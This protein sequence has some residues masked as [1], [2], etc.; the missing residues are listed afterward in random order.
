MNDALAL[1]DQ[2]RIAESAAHRDGLRGGLAAFDAWFA[3]YGRQCYTQVERVPLDELD[4]W[5]TDPD[6]GDLHHHTGRFFTVHG[7]EVG[8]PGTPVPLWTQPIIDQPEVGILGILARRIEGVLHF[9][10][11]AK[12]EPGNAGGLQLSPTVQATRS[13]YTRAHRGGSVPYLEHFQDIHR[14]PGVLADVRQSEQ[15]AW[16]YRKRNRNVVIET[17][18]EVE[19][20]EGYRWMTLGQIHR[21]LSRDDVVNM[22]AR[23]VLACLPFTGAGGSHRPGKGDGDGFAAALRRSG[24]AQAPAVHHMRDILSWITEMRTTTDVATR[25]L[26]LAALPAWQRTPQRIT[27]ESGAFFDVI[28][29]RVSARGREVRSWCQPMIEPADRGVVAFLTRTVEGVL[30]VLVHARAEAGFA[31]VVELAPTVQCIPSSYRALPPQALPP[32]LP[33][34]LDA[35]AERIR[36]DTVLS[37]EGGRFHRAHNRYL[38]VEASAEVPMDHPE[39]RW[40]TLHQ[41]AGLLRHSHYVNVQARSL[42]ACLHSL[43]G[44]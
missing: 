21:L 33:E 43:Y 12:A 13:N 28:G 20:L 29:V 23:T 24:E 4:G 3:A 37:E 39:Y 16:F 25:R 18:D 27:H 42:V 44:A 30:H 5:V 40:M 7:L 32:F 34:V 15:G 36:F 9:L 22:D 1:Q 41:L 6:T 35:P 26:P 11:Q 10:M 31:D 14:R 38:V 19:V 2:Q 17:R 8:R